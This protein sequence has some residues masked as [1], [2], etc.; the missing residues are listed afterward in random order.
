MNDYHLQTLA[1]RYLYF[2]GR[3]Q[4]GTLR[5]YAQERR[6]FDFLELFEAL[7]SL[8]AGELLERINGPA[9]EEDK[10]A[11]IVVFLWR[12]KL[13]EVPADFRLHYTFNDQELAWLPY[14]YMA[15]NGYQGVQLLPI[16]LDPVTTCAAEIQRLLTPEMN[17]EL[18]DVDDWKVLLA[19][20]S[21]VGPGLAATP[22]LDRAK[23]LMSYICEAHAG[24]EWSSFIR[25]EDFTMLMHDMNW[26]AER[27]WSAWKELMATD[28]NRHVMWSFPGWYLGTKMY[29]AKALA[30][31]REVEIPFDVD[32]LRDLVAL[33]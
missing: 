19:C 23:A 17:P 30:R 33:K 6:W 7:L 29:G 32:L 15:A 31:L 2:M 9:E 11:W 10:A 13:G 28:E 14:R 24:S 3:R 26:P 20:L 12:Q 25:L 22:Y 8:S 16:Q 18:W 5:R 27:G 4:I 21:V 1:E